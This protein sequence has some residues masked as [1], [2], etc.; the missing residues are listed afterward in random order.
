[1][2][3]VDLEIGSLYPLTQD[4]EN[5]SCDQRSATPFE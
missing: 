4:V 5:P 3:L 2:N 1:M